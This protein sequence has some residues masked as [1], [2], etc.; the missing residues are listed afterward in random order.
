MDGENKGK[1]Y[2]QMDDLG[3]KPTIFGK[4]PQGVYD[5]HNSI[6]VPYR[7]EKEAFWKHMFP[8]FIEPFGCFQK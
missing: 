8:T 4:H 3:E 2:E 1:P 6:R 7:T 5:V